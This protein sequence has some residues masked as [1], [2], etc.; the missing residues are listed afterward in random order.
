MGV[1]SSNFL[2]NQSFLSVVDDHIFLVSYLEVLFRQN[3]T[4]AGVVNASNKV[5]DD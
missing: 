1:L 2:I 3:K 4:L 5:I